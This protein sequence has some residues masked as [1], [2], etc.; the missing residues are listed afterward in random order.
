MVGL[1]TIAVGVGLAI[2]NA[3]A[4][5]LFEPLAAY[6]APPFNYAVGL[7]LFQTLFIPAGFCYYKLS[8]TTTIDIATVKET[9]TAR[10]K[11]TIGS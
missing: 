9:L 5:V 4:G 11:L 10:A 2:G 3:S 8:K 7:A 6:F 1:Q